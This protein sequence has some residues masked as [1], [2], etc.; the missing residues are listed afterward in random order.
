MS[1]K[2]QRKG[3]G[4]LTS[5]AWWNAAGTRALK[6]LAQTAMAA[7]AVDTMWDVDIRHLAGVA[8]IAAVISLLTSL[9]GIPELDGSTTD[10]KGDK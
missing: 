3:L 10:L 9:G 5:A 7:L 6:T 2:K 1:K 8:G 4:L